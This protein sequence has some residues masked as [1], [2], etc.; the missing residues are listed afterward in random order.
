MQ[1]PISFNELDQLETDHLQ[2]MLA[3]GRISD[4]NRRR[5]SYEIRIRNMESP[6]HNN[7]LITRN[8]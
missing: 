7:Q 1:K 8:Q 4:E 6:G 5:I 3:A 2:A